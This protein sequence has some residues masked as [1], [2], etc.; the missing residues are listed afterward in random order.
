MVIPRREVL[1][2]FLIV[3]VSFALLAGCWNA[4]FLDYDDL[5]HIRH[6]LVL[7]GSLADIFGPIKDST[8]FPITVLSYR[9]DSSLLSSWMTQSFGSFAPGVRFMNALYHAIG[10]LFL[11]RIFRLLR[12]TENQSLFAAIVFAAHPLACESVCWISERKNV[13]AGMFGF[14]ALYCALKFS[15][16]PWRFALVAALYFL[17]V[18]SKPS[19]LGLLPLLF[20]LELAN[21]RLLPEQAD[22]PPESLL[23]RILFLSPLLLFS[24]FAVQMTV[25]AEVHHTMVPPPGGSIFT[26]LLTDVEIYTR[27]AI[28][29]VAPLSLSFIYFVDPILSIAQ[30]RLLL[31]GAVLAAVTA[32]AIAFAPN[33]PRT[34]LGWFWFYVALAPTA[35]LVALPQIMQDRYIY[36][37][38]PGLL[39]VL[40]ELAAG[41]ARRV[42]A[43]PGFWRILGSGY[44]AL[45]LALAVSRGFLFSS[46]YLIFSDA[47]KKQP[48]AAHARYG[49]WIASRNAAALLAANREQGDAARLTALRS[50]AKT[51]AI[52]FVDSCPDNL[53]QLNF[54][55]MAISAGDYCLQDNE[56]VDA[57]RYFKLAADPPMDYM[58]TSPQIRSEALLTLAEM[59][60]RSKNPQNDLI[61]QYCERAVQ[62]SPEYPKGRF[63]RGSLAIRLLEAMHNS[64]PGRYGTLWNQARADM[65]Q[66]P[67]D[68]PFFPPAQDALAWL[69]SHTAEK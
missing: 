7:S 60:A 3:A 69:S 68:S 5:I 22:F 41:I 31:Y 50:L 49:L 63:V 58:N 18:L 33:R 38:T 59:Q 8:Y 25:G 29:I 42:K 56:L 39:L 47:V 46:T 52:A 1:H 26:A 19:A 67:K 44:I 53:R 48:L 37:S 9:L 61:Y 51:C 35:N 40:V 20:T 4:D 11:W 27:Y 55:E 64:D 65:Q 21:K 10:A 28:N 6:P 17:A 43:S 23:K 36:L 54:C 45:I 32:A 16:R 62:I 14:A 66:V 30:P 2:A 34:I 12:L 57:E 24:L 13:L 15:T